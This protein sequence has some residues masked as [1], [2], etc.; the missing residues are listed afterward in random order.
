MLSLQRDLSGERESTAIIW[1]DSEQK[2]KYNSIS[3][4]WSESKL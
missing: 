3:D 4:A 1:L 2:A